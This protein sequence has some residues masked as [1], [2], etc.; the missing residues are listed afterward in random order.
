MTTGA[1][2]QGT[3]VQSVPPPNTFVW[4]FTYMT[5][6]SSFNCTL[7]WGDSNS[8]L[9][10]QLNHPISNV[11]LF[12]G[13]TLLTQCNAFPIVA[14]QSNAI[15]VKQSLS[16]V[17]LYINNALQFAYTNQEFNPVAGAFQSACSTSN[18]AVSNLIDDIEILPV[19]TVSNAAEFLQPTIMTNV[20]VSSLFGGTVGCSSLSVSGALSNP[21]FFSL[22]NQTQTIAS[23]LV[24]VSNQV[25]GLS[26]TIN[27]LSN[28]SS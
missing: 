22:S 6:A 17:K 20:M 13:S 24:G 18:V 19:Y 3:V 28:Q 5:G 10:I 21:A 12:N 7:S 11:Q 9:S 23:S 2:Q 1:Y 26:N 16:Q 4:G 8:T 14:N 27:T 15:T 25:W